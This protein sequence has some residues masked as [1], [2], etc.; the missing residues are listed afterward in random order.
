MQQVDLNPE[1]RT[2]TWTEGTIKFPC[3]VKVEV[4]AEKIKWIM[5]MFKHE[6]NGEEIIRVGKTTVPKNVAFHIKS[7][8]T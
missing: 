5:K 6:S 1:T 2:L 7:H 4:T 8:L 3:G